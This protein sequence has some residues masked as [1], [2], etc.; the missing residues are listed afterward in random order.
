MENINMLLKDDPFIKF[1]HGG[2]DSD[3]N[4]YM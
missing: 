3:N 1:Y 2:D 4:V